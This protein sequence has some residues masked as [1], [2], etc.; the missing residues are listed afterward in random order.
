MDSSVVASLC[1][2][3]LSPERVLGVCMPEAGVTNPAD[4][5]DAREVA[6]G[7]GIRFRVVD[8]TP[9]LEGVRK[10]ITDYRVGARLPEANIKPRVRMTILYYY[11]NLLDYLVVGTG[12]RSELR[13]GYFTKFGDG[14]VDLIPLGCMYKTQ[15]RKLGERYDIPKH[16]LE[17]VPSAGL[18]RGQTDEGEL[19]LPY[20]KLDMIYV[21]LDLGLKPPEIAEAAGVGVEDV[22]RFIERELRMAHK[23]SPPPIPEL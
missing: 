11:A 6:E 20:A 3:A 23:L 5:A 16:I 18:W 4:V 9:A 15:V 14:G 22:Q 17:K 8:I 12:N 2:E 1:V 10:N 7:L 19:G 21:G 13:A